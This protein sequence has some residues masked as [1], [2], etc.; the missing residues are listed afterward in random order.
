MYKFGLIG[1]GRIAERHSF[2]LGNNIIKNAKLSAVCDVDYSR[3]EKIGKLYNVP[4]FTDMHEMVKSVDLDVLV[5]LTVSGLHAENVIELSKYKKHLIVEKPLALNLQDASNMIK[6]CDENAIRL[7]VVKQNRFN[8]PV[9]KMREAYNQKRFG[10]IF[11]ATVRVRWCRKQNYYDND[12]WRGTWSLDGGVLANQASHHI[13]ML[14]WVLGEPESVFAYSKQSIANIEAEDTAVA[15]LKFKN[16]S[17]G[18]VEATTATRPKDLEGSLS[19]LGDKGTCVIG[20]FA[21]NE[22]QTWD[23][24]DKFEGDEFVKEKYSVNPPNVYGYGHKEYYNHIIKSLEENKESFLEAHQGKKS[25]EIICG[26]Y[27]SIHLK[28]EIKFPLSS[29]SNLLGNSK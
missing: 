28:K 6:A 21:V 23:F 26:I 16:G 14:Q 13:D 10:N 11:M 27:E 7:F 5:I 29:T 19:I 20:G 24:K 15:I 8:V 4:I 22:M 3:A 18:V 9:V 12:N 25:L 1:C 2:L 17:L